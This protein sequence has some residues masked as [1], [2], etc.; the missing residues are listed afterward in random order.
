[1]DVSPENRRRILLRLGVANAE[2]RATQAQLYEEIVKEEITLDSLKTHRHFLDSDIKIVVNDKWCSRNSLFENNDGYK[3]MYQDILC[4]YVGMIKTGFCEC[5]SCKNVKT[6][7]IGVAGLRLIHIL[8]TN[9]KNLPLIAFLHESGYDMNPLTLFKKYSPLQIAVMNRCE[10]I[11]KYFV[12][13]F[14]SEEYAPT[15][16]K[17]LIESIAMN[18]Y[19]ITETLLSAKHA[20]VNFCREDGSSLFI[21]L[22][23]I[24]AYRCDDEI[25]HVKVFL[26]AGAYLDIADEYGNSPL[27]IAAKCGCVETV[28]LLLK[29]GSNVSA[30]N[31]KGDNAMHLAALS[32]NDYQAQIVELLIDKGASPDKLN[33]EGA[34]PLWNAVWQDSFKVVQTLLAASV[35]TDIKLCG[36]DTEYSR[37]DFYSLCTP[38]VGVTQSLLEVALKQ[39]DI[40]II[41]LLREA[42]YGI[43]NETG[44]LNKETRHSYKHE[45]TSYQK[46]IDDWILTSQ[47]PSRLGCLCRAKVR[48]CLGYKIHT[49]IEQLDIPKQFKTGLLF[50]NIFPSQ[51][52]VERQRFTVKFR[53]FRMSE[54]FT[55]KFKQRQNL[56]VFRPKDANG[57]ANSDDPDQTA[58]R[59]GV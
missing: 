20:D 59:G 3:Y 55:V 42:G 41:M 34:T 6:H 11:V 58:P 4:T 35:K 28:K 30:E 21:N 7:G 14:D 37:F 1:M 13:H 57:K 9:D 48:K 25:E 40:D 23:Q 51:R 49:K 45:D 46:L 43:R 47:S 38:P 10:E 15:L 22:L 2:I 16:Q 56:R 53:N 52:R 24:K 33:R 26:D 17:A 18:A 29:H 19:Y 12:Q 39:A 54:N 31:K 5:F 27:M 50:K 44:I 36:K 8:V 32:E